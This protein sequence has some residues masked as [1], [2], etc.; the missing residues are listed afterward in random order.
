MN[1]FSVNRMAKFVY[2]VLAVMILI[3]TVRCNTANIPGFPEE[4]IKKNAEDEPETN[5]ETPLSAEGK[6]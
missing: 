3:S 2:M 4:C 6:D 1:I 5:T